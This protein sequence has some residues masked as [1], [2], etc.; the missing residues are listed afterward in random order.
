MKF[1]CTNTLTPCSIFPSAL[2]RAR[3]QTW[4]QQTL[5]RMP[6]HPLG[7]NELGSKL[8]SLRA[9]GPR[10][11]PRSSGRC[12]VPGDCYIQGALGTSHGGASKVRGKFQDGPLHLDV[13]KEEPQGVTKPIASTPITQE[14][15][16]YAERRDPKLHQ[17]TGSL[18]DLDKD[19]GN[20]LLRETS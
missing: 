7:A 10:A 17:S 11:P 5:R 1:V 12:T 2:E 14:S 9:E 13:F 3:V 16:L 19:G 4:V 18:P 20:Q 6:G 15:C 8:S